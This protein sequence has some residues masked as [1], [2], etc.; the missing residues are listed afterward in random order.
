V[1]SRYIVPVSQTLICVSNPQYEKAPSRQ[2]CNACNWRLR[3][4]RT[5]STIM[6][7][8]AAW[9]HPFE[10]VYRTSPNTF[11]ELLLLTQGWIIT[12]TVTGYVLNLACAAISYLN[13][14]CLQRQ[15][16]WVD[17]LLK[18]LRVGSI[19]ARGRDP[20]SLL[21]KENLW[22][23]GGDSRITSA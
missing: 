11:R 7:C 18:W 2:P 12:N 13:I 15:L 10:Y 19:L 14:L 23:A 6:F 16:A 21:S 20:S 8:V 3:R 9:H 17:Q 4:F 5:I 22:R 1:K